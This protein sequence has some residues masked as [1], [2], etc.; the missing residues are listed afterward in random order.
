MVVPKATMHEDRSPV[1]SK[2]DVGR[3]G[4]FPRPEPEPAAQAVHDLPHDDF[5]SGVSGFDP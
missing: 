5:R 3:S 4:K 2:H 1:F